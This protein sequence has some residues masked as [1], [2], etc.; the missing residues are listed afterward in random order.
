MIKLRKIGITAGFC[1]GLLLVPAFATEES[2]ETAVRFGRLGFD[3]D[4]AALLSEATGVPRV[5]LEDDNEE[6]EPLTAPPS[7]VRF[8]KLGFDTSPPISRESSLISEPLPETTSGSALSLNEEPKA[9]ALPGTD[10]PVLPAFAMEPLGNGELGALRGGY[11]SAGGLQFDFGVKLETFVDGTLALA[12]T[13]NL[14]GQGVTETTT[15]NLPGAVPLAQ[16]VGRV[17]DLE[18][19]TGDGVVLEGHG[20]VTV[21]VQDVSLDAIRNLVVNT[22]NDRHIVQNTA[23]TLV[24]PNLQDLTQAASFNDLISSLHQ[25]LDFGLLDSVRR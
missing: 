17:P 6:Q 8:G 11:V 25:A 14:S 21:L 20:G 7:A 9:R 5:A 16:A 22:A 10:L 13:F 24:I 18:N 15:V 12:S 2:T 1:A 4:P 3:T 23:V 19:I